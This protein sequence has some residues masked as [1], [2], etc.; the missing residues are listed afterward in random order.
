MLA[1]AQSPTPPFERVLA[2]VCCHNGKN[3]ALGWADHLSTQ[4][5]AEAKELVITKYYDRGL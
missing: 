2:D 4:Q 5:E 3:A 1:V